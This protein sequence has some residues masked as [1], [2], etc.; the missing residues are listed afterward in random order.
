MVYD[1]RSLG[2]SHWIVINRAPC[3]PQVPWLHL[4]P[5]GEGHKELG[6]RP[7][8]GLSWRRKLMSRFWWKPG[9]CQAL[10]Q[11]RTGLVGR[12]SM[13]TGSTDDQNTNQY[14]GCLLNA[15]RW[16]LRPIDRTRGRIKAV[17]LFSL[18]WR[19]AGEESHLWLSNTAQVF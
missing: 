13:K 1:S 17:D 9:S 8:K 11:S 12:D 14:R 15:R 16:V 3:I 18:G 19:K 5:L 6:P 10:N 4:A 2:P 7:W